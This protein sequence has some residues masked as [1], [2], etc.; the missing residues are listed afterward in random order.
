MSKIAC[1][2]W[3]LVGDDVLDIPKTNDY[4]VHK[5]T[6]DGGVP[7]FASKNTKLDE[8]ITNI[9]REILWKPIDIFLNLL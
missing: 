4:R 5:K 3:F 7:I 2:F 8:N 6:T 1:C 9:A